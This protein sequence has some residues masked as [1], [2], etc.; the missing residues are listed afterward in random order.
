MISRSESSG[1]TI[2]GRGIGRRQVD[3][4]TI[5][6]LEEVAAIE[7]ERGGNSRPNQNGSSHPSLGTPY[8]KYHSSHAWIF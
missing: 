7:L 2:N 4:E 5:L 3:S 8:F 1:K 6:G